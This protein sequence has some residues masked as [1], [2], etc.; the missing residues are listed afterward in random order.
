MKT[1]NIKT[2]HTFTVYNAVVQFQIYTG[3]RIGET[4]ALTW[5]DINIQ[6]LYLL[7][8]MANISIVTTLIIVLLQ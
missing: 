4:L 8:M 7:R 3:M 2:R 1:N 5:I 6:N